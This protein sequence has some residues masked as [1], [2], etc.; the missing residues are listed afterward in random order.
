MSYEVS[1]NINS[2][3]YSSQLS[4]ESDSNYQS[5]T[6]LMDLTNSSSEKYIPIT[7]DNFSNSNNQIHQF[8]INNNKDLKYLAPSPEMKYLPPSPEVEH[9]KYYH[10]H[11]HQQ[12]HQ[13][14]SE[15]IHSES[16]PGAP[17]SVTQIIYED[18]SC[19]TYIRQLEDNPDYTRNFIKLEVDDSAKVQQ[20][21][22][23]AKQSR[24][25]KQNFSFE[26]DD[27]NS[28]TSNTSSSVS[29]KSKRR[30]HP[31]SYE[32]IQTQ[33]VMANVRERQRTQSLN[34]AFASLRKIIPTLPSDKLSKIQTL[35]LAAR[36]IDFLYHIL[37]QSGS[38]ES[39]SVGEDFL[40][41]TSTYM[42]HEKLSYAFSVWRMEGDWNGGNA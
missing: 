33:R 1:D 40:A 11:H 42:A 30:R 10:H 8:Y 32:D 7:L 25:R 18:G 34:E 23:N 26:S 35:K 17:Q 29:H 4:P 39:I 19:S 38:A 21:N 16:S 9:P 37:S 14:N 5:P 27:E 6:R 13:L 28:N 20:G 12:Q 36:Y 22:K 31:Q 41:N 24:K 3:Q 2:P 15:Y